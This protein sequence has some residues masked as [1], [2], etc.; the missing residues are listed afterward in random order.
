MLF[1]SRSNGESIV[2]GGGIT[3]TVISVKSDVV[4][5]GIEAP[6]EMPIHR[7]EVLQKIQEPVPD[8]LVHQD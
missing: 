7:K 6:K 1:L 4:Q 2:I 5:L 8:P 3:V